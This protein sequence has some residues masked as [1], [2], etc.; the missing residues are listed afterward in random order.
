MDD[1]GLLLAGD[2]GTRLTWMDAKIGGWAIT[3]R[4][5]KPVEIEALWYNALR[6][7]AAVAVKYR[8]TTTAQRLNGMAVRARRRFGRLFW[9][10]RAHR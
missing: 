8:D 5:G 6:T 7:V 3:P 1:D 9:N 4:D 2:A 10:E